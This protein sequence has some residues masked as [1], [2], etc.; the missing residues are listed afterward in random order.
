MQGED[1]GWWREHSLKGASA[2]RL[3]RRESGKKSGAAEQARDFFFPLC[4]LVR[5]ERGL[6]AL[7]KGAPEMGAS[8]GYQRGPQRRAWDAKGAAA[9]TK[10]SVCKHRALSTPP[11]P[12]A[13]AACHCQGPVIQGQLPRENAR[14]TS[15]WCN[16]TSASAATGSP[17][18]LYPSL[19]PARVSQS[20]RISC[21]FNPVLCEQRTDALRRPTCRGG[22]KSKAEPQELCEQRRE[23]EISPSSLRSSRLNLHNQLDGRCI[24]G[25]PEETRNHPKIEVVYFGN[26]NIY[27]FFSF[28]PFVSMYVYASKCDFVCI[29][30]LLF[31]LRFCLVPLIYVSVFVPVPYCLDDCSF[32]V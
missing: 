29:A 22:S 27:I 17:C 32:V 23:R 5:E 6:R 3:A 18:I 16:V 30:L 9:A 19:P 8:R 2:P 25:I 14:C 4:F 11:L 15:S 24:C 12:G 13:C 7:L 26:N 10:K 21:S 28:F 31:A 20:P 1:W